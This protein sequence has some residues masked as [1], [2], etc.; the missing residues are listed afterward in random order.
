MAM[1][2]LFVIWGESFATGDIDRL[3]LAVD[4]KGNICGRG[5]MED[6]E[7]GVWVDTDSYEFKICVESCDDSWDNYYVNSK[8]LNPTEPEKWVND[9]VLPYP[10]EFNRGYC[11][12]TG[13]TSI[14]GY[15]DASQ[16]A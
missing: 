1:V 13:D 2:G 15:D 14:A 3:M 4:F 7:A 12:P 5:D 6:K 9:M 16:Q 10:S 11:L 8:A